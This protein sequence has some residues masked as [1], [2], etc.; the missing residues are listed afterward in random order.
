MN[1]TQ[2]QQQSYLDLIPT[3]IT[4]QLLKNPVSTSTFIVKSDF[5][6]LFSYKIKQLEKYV[7][8]N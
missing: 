8:K 3:K 4:F 6:V 5:Y 7:T 1:A 2:F